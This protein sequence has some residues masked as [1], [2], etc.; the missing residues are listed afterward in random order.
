MNAHRRILRSQIFKILKIVS[1]NLFNKTFYNKK[2]F[3]LLRVSRHLIRNMDLLRKKRK[4]IDP[5]GANTSDDEERKSNEV[6]RE[7]V[8]DVD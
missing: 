1:I 8:K 2:E 6:E 5:K 3:P 4:E 7:P